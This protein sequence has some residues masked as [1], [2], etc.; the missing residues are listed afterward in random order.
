MTEASD[1]SGTNPSNLDSID[2]QWGSQPEDNFGYVSEEERRK[3]RGLED[4]EL[5]ESMSD[6]QP[7]VFPWFRAVIGSVIIGILLFLLFAYGLDFFMHHF[8]REL[9]GHK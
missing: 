9:L 1:Y 5:V 7:G 3:H 4:W 2:N 8:G 6:K